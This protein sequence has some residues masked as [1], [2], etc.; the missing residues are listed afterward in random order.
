MEITITDP[1]VIRTMYYDGLIV[2]S[3]FGRKYTVSKWWRREHERNQRVGKQ[4][5]KTKEI[6]I[7]KHRCRRNPGLL[8]NHWR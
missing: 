6:T 7:P 1:G 5:S 4:L 3:P 8:S 2:K